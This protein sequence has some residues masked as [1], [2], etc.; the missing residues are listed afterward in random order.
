[1]HMLRVSVAGASGYAGGELVRWLER[2]PRVEL[3]HLTAF[4]EQGRPIADIF[5]N[6]RGIV[7][8]T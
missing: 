1:M 2:H 7:S 3:V 8:Q 5:P 6:L 4:R